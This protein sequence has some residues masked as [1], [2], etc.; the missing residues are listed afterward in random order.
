MHA[1]VAAALLLAGALTY[2][3]QKPEPFAG[4][5]D[6]HPAIDYHQGQPRD[7]VAQLAGAIAERRASLERVGPAGYLPSLLRALNISTESQLLV[8]SKTGVQRSSTGPRSP[9]AL[10]FD[11]SVVVGYIPGARYIEIAAH[12]AQQGVVF[13]TL[14]QFASSSAEPSRQTTCLT[15]HVSGSTMDVPGLITRSNFTNADGDLLP[16]LGFHLV[17][18]RTPLSQR[19]GGWFVTGKYDLAPYGGVTHMGNVATAIHPVTMTAAGTSNEVLFEWLK[20]DAASL[21]YPSQDSDIAALMV[22]DHQ[23]HAINLLTRLNWEVRV[24]AASGAIDYSSGDLKALT[25]ELADYLL[26]ADEVP[27]PARLMPRAGFAAQFV[28]SA[29]RDA[30]GRSLRD[31]DLSTRLLKHSC[32]YMIYSAAFEALPAAA[33]RAV[34]THMLNGLEDVTRYP[35]LTSDDRTA[36]KA[37]LRETKADWPS[38]K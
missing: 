4:V 15:C 2:A 10:Y 31:L 36:L 38:S 18:H 34:Y 5:L 28:S 37:I 24:A 16:Q 32:S 27:P 13:Y 1:L 17:D 23:A 20:T 35:H 8:F 33:R 22:F 29:R 7:R 12:D 19:W 3:A 25:R 11:D 21:G 26:F 6:E 14:D 9:R 30:R